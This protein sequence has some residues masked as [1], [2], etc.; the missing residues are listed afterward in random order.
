[1]SF[2]AAIA[3]RHDDLEVEQLLELLVEGD[4]EHE[5]EL[6]GWVELPR[7]YGADGIAGHA[8]HLGELGLRQPRLCAGLLEIVLQNQLVF[9]SFHR[10]MGEARKQLIDIDGGEQHCRECVEDGEHRRSLAFGARGNDD[11]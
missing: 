9:H 5:G 2:G 4:A 1:M 7:F 3:R 8:N 11:G 10:L 6:G